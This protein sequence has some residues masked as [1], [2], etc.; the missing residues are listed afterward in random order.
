MD[1]P[2]AAKRGFSDGSIFQQLENT[3]IFLL[4][5]S[6]IDIINTTQSESNTVQSEQLLQI[7]D[8]GRSGSTMSFSSVSAVL[9]LLLE[10]G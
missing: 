6:A 2:S 1:C 10:Q 9:H 4:N 8:R 7:N 5:I 3:F